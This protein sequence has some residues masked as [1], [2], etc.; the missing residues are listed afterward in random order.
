[1]SAKTNKLAGI[2]LICLVSFFTIKCKKDSLTPVQ[3]I[4]PTTVSASSERLIP[5]SVRYLYVGRT[6]TVYNNPAGIRI[7]T[8]YV[9]KYGFTG[10]YM[11]TT[12]PILASSANYA[13]FGNFLKQLTDSGVVVKA[14]ISGINSASYFAINGPVDMYNKS[15]IDLAKKIN[16][17]N[18]ELEWW[19]AD[20]DWP[21]WNT[22][23]QSIAA[24]VIP[25]NDFYEGWY[26]NLGTTKD[27]IA[28]KDQVRY[29][30]RILMHCYQTTV[31]T[32]SYANNASTGTT[33]GR[34][35]C[36]AKGARQEYKRT[37]ILKKVDLYIMISAQNTAWGSTNTYQGPILQQAYLAGQKNPFAYIESQAYSNIYGSMT[38]FQKQWIN[39]KGFVWFEKRYC[40]I[41][42]PPSK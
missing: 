10:V 21:T 26:K 22:V 3:T 13:T 16:R 40:Y 28:S 5:P 12:Q 23:N 33:C 41:A 19:N 39:F 11:Y 32:Y 20:C 4:T 35:D 29:S 37:S 34:L 17:S 14:V 6:D 8:R 24:G 27:T 36:I 2:L 25:D 15:Q 42:V 1:M 7:L 9:K 31:P 30:D 38:T 18:L